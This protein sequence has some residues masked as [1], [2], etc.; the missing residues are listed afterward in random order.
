MISKRYFLVH[1][2]LLLRRSCAPA[3]VGVK[4]KGFNQANIPIYSHG[5]RSS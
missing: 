3:N 1:H 5:V 2:A 4:Q